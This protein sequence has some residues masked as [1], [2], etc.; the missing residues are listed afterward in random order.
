MEVAAEVEAEV[1]AAAET[2]AAVAAAAV[3]YKGGCVVVSDPGRGQMNR[4]PDPGPRVLEG[5]QGP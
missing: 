5:A 4:L 3:E 1:E 2:E